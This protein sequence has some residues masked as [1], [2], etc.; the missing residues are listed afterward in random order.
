MLDG[1]DAA[2]HAQ[3]IVLSLSL[4]R[5]DKGFGYAFVI[6]TAPE[7]SDARRV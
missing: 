5:S 4:Y 6:N 7:E 2:R 1:F 3:R